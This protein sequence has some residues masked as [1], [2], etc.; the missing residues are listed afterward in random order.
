MAN[1]V[2]ILVEVDPSGRGAAAIKS[3]TAQVNTMGTRAGAASGKAGAAIAGVGSSFQ[4]LLSTA[5]LTTAGVVAGIGYVTQKAISDSN[6]LA[7]AQRVLK[8]DAQQAGLTFEEA[9]A[10]ALDFGKDLAL[11]NKEAEVSFARFVRVVSAAG[12]TENLDKYRKEFAD[13]AA[14]YG[15]SAS[16][17]E[18][19][20]NQLLSGQDEALNRLGIADPSKL[21]ERYAANIG[22]T[23]EQLTQEEQVRARLLAVTEKGEQF[24]GVAQERLLSQVG[25]WAQMYANIENASAALGDFLQKSTPVGDI[26]LFANAA[27]EGKSPITAKYDQIIRQQDAARVAAFQK[28]KQ[29]SDTFFVREF[30]EAASRNQNPYA[31]FTNL[32]NRYGEAEAKKMRDGFV[33]QYSLLFK[34]K[35]LTK[36]TALFA[37]QQFNEIKGILSP[38]KRQ[39]IT[40]QFTQFW[41]KYAGV[42][43]S[44]LK[45]VRGAAEKS[46]GS[47]A[48]RF[49]GG[50]NPIVKIMVEGEE[51]AREFSRTFG[52]LGDKTVEDLQRIEAAFVRQKV[53]AL[54][55]DS[56]L[57]AASLRREADSLQNFKGMTGADDRALNVFNARL[58]AATSTAEL[59]A[60]AEAISEGRVGNR[61]V[62]GEERLQ[63]A[64]A[65]RLG[66]LPVDLTD[67][68]KFRAINGRKFDIDRDDRKAFFAD[69]G[70]DINSDTVFRETLRAL[71]ELQGVGGGELGR[72]TSAALNDAAINLFNS[73]NGDLQAQ[74]AGGQRGSSRDF[75]AGAFRGQAE[76]LQSRI[77]DEIEKGRVADL[78][79]EGVRQDMKL[80]ADKQREG[81]DSREADKRLLSVTGELSPGDLT[82]DIRQA[83][84]EALRREADRAANAQAEATE[85]VNAARE[86][87]D[88]L[89][90]SVDSLA[91]E[92]RRPENRRLLIDINNKA[93]AF[94]RGELYGSLLNEDQ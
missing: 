13:L 28:A 84:I 91:E 92:I 15:L 5:G 70:L 52:L 3:I 32:T 14:A 93:T 83:R 89:T 88:K 45:S 59:L 67:E 7:N 17:V 55:L 34:D 23:T 51:A 18:V 72:R 31:N 47:L 79:L 65:E 69:S 90:E 53:L 43:L 81:L 8:S 38:E 49:A 77:Q 71:E 12:L 26:P 76:E 10:K 11:S 73:L 36:T 35:S 74:I 25:L 58:T 82:A 54:G 94:V 48:D 78:A 1:K 16:E 56:E 63:I 33:E 85:A 21:Y 50:E 27:F 68:E 46:F 29:E 41:D 30:G 44:A 9:R 6:A 66:K 4:G 22:K 37:E 57:R 64:L 20:T 80:I 19:L 40:R 87:T 60:R 24:A 61:Q 75:F 39:E 62:S 42:A 2:E 86:A